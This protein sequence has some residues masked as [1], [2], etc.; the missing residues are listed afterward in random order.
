MSAFNRLIEEG[1]EI[2]LIALS[3]GNKKENCNFFLH[4][5][6]L[7]RRKK[8]YYEKRNEIGMAIVKKVVDNHN[9]YIVV[10]SKVDE[11]TTFDI[12]LPIKK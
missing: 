6:M 11:G 3:A 4:L 5:I 10:S 12:N 1:A 7:T 8:I 2:F 9:G